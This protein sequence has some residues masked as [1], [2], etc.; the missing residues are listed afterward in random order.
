MYPITIKPSSY[1]F[2]Q[3]SD[4]IKFCFD[5]LAVGVYQDVVPRGSGYVNAGAVNIIYANRAGTGLSPEGN[6]WWFQAYD[7][8]NPP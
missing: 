6:Q 7:P 5:D 1:L 4:S 2:L 8:D 3:F